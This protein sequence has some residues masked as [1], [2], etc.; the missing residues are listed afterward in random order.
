MDRL[1]RLVY[2]AAPVSFNVF[3]WTDG[4]IGVTSA[5]KVFIVV[6]KTSKNT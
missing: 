3:C 2:P 1:Y 6:S 5:E 4:I